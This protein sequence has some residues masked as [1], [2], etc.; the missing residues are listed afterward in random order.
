MFVIYC[1]CIEKEY[2]V[3][4]EGKLMFLDVKIVDMIVEIFIT[5]EGDQLFFYEV[6]EEWMKKDEL[7]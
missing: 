1:K 5:Y 2:M 4:L 7:N 6:D 3:H